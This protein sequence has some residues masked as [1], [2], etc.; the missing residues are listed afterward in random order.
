MD[1]NATPV[2]GARVQVT[3]TADTE[4]L[5]VEHQAVTDAHGMV[6]FRGIAALGPARFKVHADGFDPMSTTLGAEHWVDVTL[7]LAT[8]N[9][10]YGVI[11]LEDGRPAAI[12]DVWIGDVSTTSDA[13]G[14]FQLP[15]VALNQRLPIVASRSDTATAL[16][17]FDPWELKELW[18]G[19][20]CVLVLPES[21]LTIS[22]HL[23]DGNGNGLGGFSYYLADP[24][25]DGRGGVIERASRRGKRTGRT[26][27]D[28][29]FSVHGLAK[30]DYRL[31]FK[32]GTDEFSARPIAAG[33]TDV[34]IWKP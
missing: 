3:V 22:G 15:S 30:R 19:G 5:R 25:D 9:L 12:A 10:F 7:E 17:L 32:S 21:P 18:A 4:G 23:V 28:G 11:L 33:R 14:R 16:K 6:R 1:S 34:M 20:E 13:E 27:P 31:R 29:S 26:E 2:E 24:T 8:T